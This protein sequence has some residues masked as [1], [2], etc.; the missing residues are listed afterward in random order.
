LRDS[1]SVTI[2]AGC[3]VAEIA[4]TMI[5]EREAEITDGRLHSGIGYITPREMNK[6][7]ME[8]IQK[9]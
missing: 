7:C 9:A 6:K 8:K 2:A 4:K 5:L 3:S 1:I